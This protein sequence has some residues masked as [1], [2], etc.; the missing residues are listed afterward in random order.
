MIS[1]HRVLPI[2]ILSIFIRA[3][4]QVRHLLER[5]HL[6]GVEQRK[7]QKIIQKGGLAVKKVISLTQVLLYTFFC[8]SIFIP[9]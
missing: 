5:F 7:E 1:P 9:F 8:N 6:E 3:I 4:Q 2:A